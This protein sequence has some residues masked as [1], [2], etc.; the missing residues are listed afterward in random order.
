MKKVLFSFGVEEE[1]SKNIRKKSIL[2]IRVIFAT[3]IANSFLRFIRA[4]VTKMVRQSHQKTQST[5][6]RKLTTSAIDSVFKFL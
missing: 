1:S 3:S 6:L 4:D 5:A 2:L